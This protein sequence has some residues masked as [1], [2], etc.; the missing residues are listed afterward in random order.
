MSSKKTKLNIGSDFDG[1]I[2]DHSFQKIK[3]AKK[4]NY[5]LRPFETYSDIMKSIIPKDTAKEIQKSIYGELT[6]SSPI[7]DFAKE[8]LEELTEI[9]NPIKIISRRG[10][11]DNGPK[12]AI[13][14][15][16]KY[17]IPPIK[18]EDVF[19]VLEDVEKDELAKKLKINVYIDDKESVLD[20]M[21]FVKY[22][23]HFYPHGVD[24]K[25][26]Y[27]VVRSWREFLEICKKL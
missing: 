5:D 19:F 24:I 6:L 10:V 21:P 27:P 11:Y 20:K 4:Y 13:E 12:Y 1:T 9:F 17:V 15:M 18:V 26:K 25:S 3:L 8:V 14:W 7:T 22:R 2:I 16:R 23:F